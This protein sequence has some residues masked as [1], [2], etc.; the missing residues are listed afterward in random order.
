MVPDAVSGFRAFSRHAAIELNVLTNFSYT[1][2]T[3][4]Q[5][6]HRRT[7]IKSIPIRTEKVTR[8]SRLFTNIPAFV[9]R[10]V[11]TL[12]RAYAMYNALRA[13]CYVGGLFVT[14]GGIAVAR[15]LYFYAIGNGGGHIQSVVIGSGFFVLGA[16]T[17]LIGIVADLIAMN[18]RLLEELLVRTRRLELNARLESDAENS[19]AESGAEAADRTP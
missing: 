3:I 15:F 13:F 19:L 18:R 11:T 4:L 17:L 5:A 12:L 14:V 6:A 7:A 9:T 1:I 10:S 16:I 8:P 2:E